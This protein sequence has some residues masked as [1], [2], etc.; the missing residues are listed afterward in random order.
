MRRMAFSCEVGVQMRDGGKIRSEVS[1]HAIPDNQKIL[2][3]NPMHPQKAPRFGPLPRK[4]S[5]ES[6]SVCSQSAK[7][8]CTPGETVSRPPPI[9]TAAALRIDSGHPVFVCPCRRIAL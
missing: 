9:D 8:V 5:T 4:H 1:C 2:P 6:T 3:R 7:Y